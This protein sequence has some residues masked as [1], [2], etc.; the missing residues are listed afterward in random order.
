VIGESLLL[1][2][3]NHV[4]ER[5]DNII[6]DVVREEIDTYFDENRFVI[7]ETDN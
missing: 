5:D 7:D 6:K 4:V 1:T 3:I 2:D